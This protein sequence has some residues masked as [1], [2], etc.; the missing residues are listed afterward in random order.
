MDL[1]KHV[2]FQSK[3]SVPV[4]LSECS[5]YDAKAESTGSWK[6][7]AVFLA[8]SLW[9]DG[10]DTVQAIKE[11]SGWQASR[12]K[13]DNLL[14]S[15]SAHMYQLMQTA[16]CFW[17]Q[18]AHYHLQLQL[19]TGPVLTGSIGLFTWKQGARKRTVLV[20]AHSVAAQPEEQEEAW[21]YIQ[22]AACPVQLEMC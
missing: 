21:M 17:K 1:Q 15:P 16:R 20:W 11:V 12:L 3:T 5:G 7:K 9:S 6:R 13:T 18:A 4:V 8:L 14:R 10:A 22:R 19:H 2:R